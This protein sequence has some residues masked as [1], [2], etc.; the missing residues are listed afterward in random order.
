VQKKYAAN[1]LPIWKSLFDDPAV[2]ATNPEVVAVSKIQYDYIRNRPQVPYYGEL[3]TELQSRIQQA[4]L[5]KTTPK[6]ALEAVQALAQKLA[7]KK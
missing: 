6:A 3:S 1:A 4:L 5:R 2:V 7:A